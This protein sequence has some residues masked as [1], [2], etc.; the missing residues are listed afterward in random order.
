M[1]KSQAVYRRDGR[2]SQRFPRTVFVSKE[3]WLKVRKMA[4]NMSSW[5]DA[6]LADEAAK[7]TGELTEEDYLSVSGPEP[8]K[9]AEEV[10]PQ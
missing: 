4:G 3:N 1:K 2:A 8:K 7:F 9:P 6:I 5:V 10:V